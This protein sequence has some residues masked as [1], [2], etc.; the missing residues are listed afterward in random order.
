MKHPMNISYKPL[1]IATKIKIFLVVISFDFILI[2]RYDKF[3][4]LLI[5][6]FLN[7]I[8]IDDSKAYNWLKLLGNHY[9]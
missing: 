3:M 7:L 6:N 5:H 9:S 4:V 2:I 8:L 1:V